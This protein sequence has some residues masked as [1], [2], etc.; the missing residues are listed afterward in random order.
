M[1]TTQQYFKE[2][3]YVVLSNVVDKERCQHLTDHMFKLAESGSTQNDTQCP[4]SDGIYGDPEFEKLL[5]ELCSP[6]GQ[7]VGLRLLPTYTYARLY[8]PGEILKKH[9]D[10]P[11]CEV[12][13]TL[14]LGYDGKKVWPILFDDEKHIS[15]DLD[16]GEMAVYRGCE[17]THWREPFKGVWHV[18]V[19]LHYVDADGPYND[20]IFDKRPCL[21]HHNT[22]QQSAV[23]SAKTESRNVAPQMQTQNTEVST[24]IRK[25][26]FNSVIIPS[27]DQEFP[28]YIGINSQHW[29]ELMFTKSE[30]NAI[31]G[32]VEDLYAQTSSV[33]GTKEDSKINQQIRSADIFLLENDDENRWIYEKVS[34]ALVV[35][36][37]MH[38]DYDLAGI[39]HSIQLIRYRANADVAGHYDWHVDCG[40]GEPATR[41]ISFVAQLSNPDHYEG[42]ELIV[43]DHGNTIQATKE[44]G[45]ISMFPSYQLHKVEPIT[46]GERYSLVVWVH[47]SGR[48]R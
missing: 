13:A 6:I 5:E 16:I 28:G 36:N 4:L 9:K 35:A 31:I 45:S 44:Q 3:K 11:S 14:T 27:S 30:C 25:A 1:S 33:G 10:R 23:I 38:F 40:R 2:N 21:G 26:L 42:C 24:T 48:F 15:V 18:Q 7:N 8:R 12:S 41:K 29:P 43:N 46:Q 39:N 17:V 19:F 37:K 34:N 20:Y 22:E 47:G 32:M